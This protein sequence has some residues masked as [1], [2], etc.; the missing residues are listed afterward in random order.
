MIAAVGVINSTTIIGVIGLLELIIDSEVVVI[1]VV[2]VGVVV[3]WAI[4]VVV[5][6]L[7]LLLIL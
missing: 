5:T 7:H 3:S 4:M 2:V 1:A 6:Q